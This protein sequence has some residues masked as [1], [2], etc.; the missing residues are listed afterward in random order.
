MHEDPSA[1]QNTYGHSE[2][3]HI[4]SRSG[5]KRLVLNQIIISCVIQVTTILPKSTTRIEI[6]FFLRDKQFLET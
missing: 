5:D 6:F 1:M 2:T 4:L 3:L